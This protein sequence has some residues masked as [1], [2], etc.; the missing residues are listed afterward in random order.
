MSVILPNGNQVIANFSESVFLNQLNQNHVINNV[1]YISNLTFN[2]LS[3]ANLIDNLSCVKHLN[4]VVVTFKTRTL[5]KL[6][7]QL[8]CKIDFIYSE[9]LLI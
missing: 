3:I 5:W 7:V 2:L 9:S 4:L 8:I 1:M 6:L